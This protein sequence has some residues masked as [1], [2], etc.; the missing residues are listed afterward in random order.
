MFHHQSIVGCDIWFTFN[1]INNDTFG[2]CCRRRT[3]LDE[4][5]ESCASHARNTGVFYTFHYYLG[6]KFWMRSHRLQ[7]IGTVNAF[8]PFVTIH[9]YDNR[10]LEIP[11]RINDIVDF[12][13]RAR[14]RRKNRRRDEATRL[15][16]HCTHLYLVTL[17]NHRFC[18]GSNMLRKWKHCLQR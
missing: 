5:G 7:L 11:R 18:W 6:C 8:L 14:H 13:N 12:Q 10:R 15:G 3:Q 16:N 2:L 4:S 1:C 9:F 17:G